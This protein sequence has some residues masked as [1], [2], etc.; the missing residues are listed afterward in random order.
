MRLRTGS[1]AG[2]RAW[3]AGGVAALAAIVVAGTL[4]IFHYANSGNAFAGTSPGSVVTARA[5]AA[6]NGPRN[7]AGP[8]PAASPGSQAGT[9]PGTPADS[10]PTA[11]AAP[12]AAA[13]GSAAQAGSPAAAGTAQDTGQATAP[14]HFRT[15]PP[16]TS[17]PTS[18]Q[19]ARWVRQRPQAENKAANKAANH[20]TG[21]H[22]PA[23][24]FAAGDSPKAGKYLA[25]RINGNFTGT[26]K[27]IL[28]WAA[29]K[30]GIDQSVVF[31]QAAVESWWQQGTLG[32]WGTDASACPPGHKLGADGTAGQCPQSYGILQNRYPYEA[33]SWPGIGRS[34]AMNADTAYAIW[35]SCYDGYETWLNDVPHGQPYRKGDLWG[36][37]GRWFAG[38]WHTAP[39]HQYVTKVKA[40]EREKIWLTK[41]FQ[42][43]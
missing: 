30:W 24:F 29:C 39:A 25:R 5:A 10:G 12:A 36:C 31:A 1:H 8:A 21:Q 41:D 9:A 15:V 17:L 22:V 37:V 19:C 38:R 32:D 16:G 34:T 6:T 23:S 28:R 14:A 42:Q 3:L 11:P 4:A 35:R 13:S 18:A 20:R 43:G 27:E 26:T 2:R 33:S 7:P 40:Y